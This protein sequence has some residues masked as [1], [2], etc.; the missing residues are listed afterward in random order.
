MTALDRRDLVRGL[1]GLAGAALLGTSGPASA[2]SQAPPS[3]AAGACS[4]ITRQEIRTVAGDLVPRYFDQIPSEEMQLPGGGSVCRFGGFNVQLDPIAA[5]DF[6][7]HRQAQAGRADYRPAPGVGDTAYFFEQGPPGSPTSVGMFV[8]VRGR[9]F[10]VSMNVGSG[11]A[12]EVLRPAV[13]GLAR[14]AALRL[15]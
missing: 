5:A 4:L 12:A 14:V 6:D 9:V 7:A 10:M 15:R 11:E 8:R 3:D 2:A 13:E 1:A